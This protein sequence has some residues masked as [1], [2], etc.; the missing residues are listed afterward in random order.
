MLIY[1]GTKRQFNTDVVNNL[2]AQQI[3]KAFN[4]KG[5]SHDNG[6][7]FLAWQNALLNR[8]SYIYSHFTF[9]SEE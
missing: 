4:S 2:I 7:E 6:S 1:S 5:L 3:E 8:I 9:L